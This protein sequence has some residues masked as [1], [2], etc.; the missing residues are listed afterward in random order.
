MWEVQTTLASF[1]VYIYILKSI[2]S[3]TCRI[4]THHP[5]P[6]NHAH[7]PTQH[8]ATRHA[9]RMRER[10]LESTSHTKLGY[11]GPPTFYFV[12][13]KVCGPIPTHLCKDKGGWANPPHL[14]PRNEEWGCTYPHT[15]LPRQ[16]RRG[17]PTPTHLCP[18]K[19]EGGWTYSPHTFAHTRKKGVYLPPHTF[20][21]KK[22]GGPTPT[23][24]CPR[25]EEGGVPR[26]PQLCG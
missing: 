23:H 13:A 10:R 15:P 21:H 25:K 16:R 11:L 3:E 1:R 20:P 7:Q 5:P 6:T 24:L 2:Y 4:T 17:V 22:V 19:V 8:A 9:N 26:Y 14:C 12:W 18:D